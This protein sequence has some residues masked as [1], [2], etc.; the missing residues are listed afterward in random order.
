MRTST[1]IVLTI[2]GWLASASAADW[3]MYRADAERSG[4]SAEELPAELALAWIYQPTHPPTPAWPRDDRMLFDRA[5]DVVIGGGVVLFGTSVEGRVIALDPAT[6]REKWSFFTDAPVR[7]A[8]AIWKDRAYAVSD[9]GYLYCLALADGSLR[10]KWRGGPTDE[11]ILGN[12]RMVSRW[13]ARGGPVVRDGIVYW[14]AGIWQSEGIFLRAID[15]ESGR[16]IWVNDDAGSI[17]MPQPHGGASAESGVSAQGYLVATAG[18]LL[19]PTGRAV[20]AAFSRA[21]GKFRYY[22]LQANGHVGGTLTVAAGEAF[23]NGGTAFNLASGASEGKLGSGSVAKFGE[24]I[25]HGSKKELRALKIVEKTVPDRKGEPTQSRSHEVVWSLPGVDASAA[26]IVAGKAIFA[27][28]GTSVTAVDAS[29]QKVI[30]TKRVD[31]TPHGLAA[32]DG[33]LYVSTDRGTIHCYAAASG[34]PASGGQA[35]GGRRPTEQTA[36]D[37]R[38]TAAADEILRRTGVKEGYCLDLDCGDGSLAIAL[39]ERSNLQIYALSPPADQVAAVR[40]RLS[41]RGLYGV[42]ITVHQGDGTNYRYGK[43]FADLVVSARSLDAGPIAIPADSPPSVLRPGGGV[44]CTGKPRS[45]QLFQRPALA[46]AGS[47]TH[48]YSDLGN[49]SCS[50]DELVQG[51]LRTLWFRDV[52]LEMPQ[53]H[54]R[55]HAPL[56]F[57]GRMFVEG[58]DA[59]RGVDAYNGRNLWEFKLPGIQSAFN[60]D[61]LAGTAVTGSNF[62]VAASGVYVHDKQRCYRL[63]PATGQKLG[64]FPTPPGASGKPGQWGYI[65]CDGKRLFGSLANPDHKVRYAYLR[66]DMSDMWGESRTFFAM[67]AESGRLLWR[68]DAQ[69]SIRNNAI[70]IGTG[71]VFLIDRA[72]AKEDLW[73]PKDPSR[74]LAPVKE[75]AQPPGTLIALDQATGKTTWKSEGDAWGTMLAYSQE[76]DALLMGYQSTRFKLPSEVGGKLAVFRGTS[77][78]PLWQKQAKYVTRPLINDRKIYAQGGSWDLLTGE[79]QPFVFDRSYGCGQ[80]AG[81][82]H[83]LLF[84]SA[85]LGYLDLTRGSGVE[86]FGGIRPGCWINA[87]PVGGLVLVPDASAG[88]QCS[89]QNRSWMA[90]TGEE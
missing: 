37:A 75:V 72:P 25:V 16:E 66:A 18:D 7:F 89:Y 6:G 33:R 14:G 48:Q 17:F 59:V 69:H 21:G 60:A 24:G 80:L 85:T 45:M 57:Q 73:D 55:G 81:S 3:P 64:E 53:R 49:T 39:A 56:F 1:L 71:Q 30:W 88:C 62:C 52:D 76:H 79:D 2:C 84:R 87:L 43:Y 22:H 70:A 34:T 9:D 67:D 51:Q 68:Y 20:P 65:A 26:L 38:Y 28:G 10:Q 31:G 32:S 27:G 77:G 23:Y 54:G 50:T 82:R 29:S 63:D 40:K 90:L 47:W 5:H 13:P 58:L 46:N 83:M 4:N 12:G 41:D 19:V 78:K 15:A 36:V 44:A 11:M 35:S 61:H 74:K 86:N 42:R 8:P